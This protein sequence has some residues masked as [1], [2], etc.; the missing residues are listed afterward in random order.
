MKE[1]K[2]SYEIRN[3]KIISLFKFC[4]IEIRLIGV[5]GIP[6]PAVIYDNNQVLR[7]YVSP[8]SIN[9]KGI[10]PF[11]LKLSDVD[12]LN[13]ENKLKILEWFK[14]TRH[15]QCYSIKQKYSNTY[16][17]GYTFLEKNSLKGRRPVFSEIN[18]KIYFNKAYAKKIIRMYQNDNLQ[19]ILI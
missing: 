7:C 8:N 17:S 2:R 6:N 3:A 9:F 13:K 19:L 16:L 14:N 10:K 11:K 15:K 1:K 5:E 12:Y 4:G 18:R